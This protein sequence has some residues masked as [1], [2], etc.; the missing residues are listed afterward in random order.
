MAK[1]NI[2]SFKKFQKELKRKEKAKEKL[3]RRQGKKEETVND[4]DEQKHSDWS[5]GYVLCVRSSRHRSSFQQKIEVDAE[6]NPDEGFDYM[7][8][9]GRSG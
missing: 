8:S 6:A 3:T 5:T 2:H 1:R 4:P 9:E 7:H